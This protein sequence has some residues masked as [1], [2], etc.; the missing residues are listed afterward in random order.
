M[1][2][3]KL[4]RDRIP[5]IIKRGSGNPITHI[6]QPDELKA[7]LVDKLYEEFNEFL[8]GWTL[9]ELADINEVLRALSKV[10][11]SNPEQLER[12]RQEKFKERGGFSGGIV[13]EKVE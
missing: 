4:V 10:I 12:V 1:R 9:E 7:R 2:Y 5:E 6:A 3:N 8:K 11:G 13:L